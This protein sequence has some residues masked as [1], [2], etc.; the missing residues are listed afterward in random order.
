MTLPD[1]FNKCEHNACVGVI[2]A[3]RKSVRKHNPKYAKKCFDCP[4]CCNICCIFEIDRQL[5]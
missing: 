1:C 4:Y 5:P 3:I 2:K